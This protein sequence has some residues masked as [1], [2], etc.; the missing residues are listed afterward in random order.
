MEIEL[1]RADITSISVDAMVN[2]TE[3]PFDDTPGANLL[4]RFIVHVPAPATGDEAALRASTEHS[5]ER[6]EELAV[7][8]V[9]LPAFWSAPGDS[10]RCAEVM[11]AAT[12]AFRQ[13]ARSLRR[14][15]YTLFGQ[16]MF[17]EFERVLRKV[18]R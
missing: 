14:V 2:P 6:A 15:V 13:R 4:C 5:L 18:D 8:S 11:L 1:I 10:T 3:S 12:V 9:A 17:D 7:A 16:T